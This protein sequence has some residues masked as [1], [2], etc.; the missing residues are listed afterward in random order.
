MVDIGV[1]RNSKQMKIGHTGLA[2]H[3]TLRERYSRGG[4]IF[5]LER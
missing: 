5:Q 4:L 1:L 3:N 2:L